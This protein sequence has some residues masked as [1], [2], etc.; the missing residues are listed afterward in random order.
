[1]HS[2]PIFDLT[3]RDASA[4]LEIGGRAAT[5][6]RSDGFSIY[7][8]DLFMNEAYVHGFSNLLQQEIIVVDVR[9]KQL[10]IVCYKP[11]G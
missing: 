1:M 10:T 11:G 8:S 3:L 5:V 6:S 9:E 2:D 4:V 7:Q